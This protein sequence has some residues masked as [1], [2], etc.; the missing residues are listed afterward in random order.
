MLLVSGIIFLLKGIDSIYTG[1]TW[2]NYVSYLTLSF[3]LLC[4]GV[5]YTVMLALIVFGVP[6]YEYSDLP[7]LSEG[8]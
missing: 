4:P 2:D 7:D 6:G 3:L 8:S 1:E 5:F